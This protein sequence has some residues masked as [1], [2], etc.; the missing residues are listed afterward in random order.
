MHT[1]Y[2]YTVSI[3]RLFVKGGAKVGWERAVARAI[4]RKHYG[5]G[6]P[7]VGQRSGIAQPRAES[8]AATLPGPRAESGAGDLLLSC[9][10]LLTLFIDIMLFSRSCAVCLCVCTSCVAL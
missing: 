3:A 7:P 2:A 1:E 10:K 5:E 6:K 8:G 9:R 4:E